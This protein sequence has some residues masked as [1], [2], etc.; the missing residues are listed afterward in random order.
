M[1]LKKLSISEEPMFVQLAKVLNQSQ[2]HLHRLVEAVADR[3][4]KRFGKDRS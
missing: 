1:E 2:V 4:F 3:A